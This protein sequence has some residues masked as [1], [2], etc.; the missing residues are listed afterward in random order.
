MIG[1]RVEHAAQVDGHRCARCGRGP[2]GVEELLARGDQVASAQS[3][4]LRIAQDHPTAARE[5]VQ[6]GAQ[7]AG[8]ERRQQRLHPLDRDALGDL[9]QQIGDTRQLLDELGR[10]RPHRRGEQQLATR[11]GPQPMFD[12]L[13][14]TLVGDPEPPDL[15]D[16]VAPELDPHRVLV[17][18]GEDIEQPA[19]DGELAALLD[20]VGAGVCRRGQGLDHLVKG[21]FVAG[22]K[23]HRHEVAQP[24]GQGLQHRPHRRHDHLHR[25]VCRVV[26]I[27]VG[28]PAQ[29]GQAP[30]NG[31]GAR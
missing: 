16:R 15:L 10:P 18:R 3:D 12:D 13:Q 21:T 31:V 11:R 23:P 1:A 6:D 29:H 30:P 27:R 2:A 19:P 26:Q 8:H 17:G 7:L 4:P 9:G 14:R 5:L 20:Q 28:P 24:G 22:P 25:P